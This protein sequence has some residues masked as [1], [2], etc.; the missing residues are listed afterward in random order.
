MS[1]GYGSVTMFL[2]PMFSLKTG[3]LLIELDRCG[4]NHRT[5]VLLYKFAGDN[6]DGDDCVKSRSGLQRKVNARV[7]TGEEIWDD[8]ERSLLT[9]SC[10]KSFVA[11]GVDEGQFITGLDFLAKKVLDHSEEYPELTM[12]LFV[13][14]LDST[15]EGKMWPEIVNV[16]P[17]STSIEKCL[18]VCAFCQEKDANLTK[19]TVVS[20]ELILIGSE[21]SYLAACYSC[22]RK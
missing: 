8:I 6:R 7:R 14:A 18:S 1:K 3:R 19:R 20:D 13:S 17:F 22:F 10:I 2:G 21:E 12:N 5:S 16:I 9:T 15:F 11:I 4:F